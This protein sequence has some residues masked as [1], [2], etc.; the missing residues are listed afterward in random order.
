M[1]EA[2]EAGQW[3]QTP[4]LKGRPATE[5]DIE[6]GIAVFSIPS[7]SE[8]YNIDLPVCVILIDEESGGRTPAITIEA[9]C[10]DDGVFL[11][12]RYI[13]GG[14][15]VCTIKGVEFLDGPTHEFGL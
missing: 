8:A 4:C 15:G 2:I 9:E 13:E 10:A 11:G 6:N 12:V 5:A 14:N 7:G 1:W 3:K